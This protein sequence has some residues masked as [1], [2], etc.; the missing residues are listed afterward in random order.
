MFLFQGARILRFQALIFRGVV[1]HL[2]KIIVFHQPKFPCQK[3]W[4]IALPNVT[5]FWGFLVATEVAS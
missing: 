2:A 5:T 4:R 3:G 1:I